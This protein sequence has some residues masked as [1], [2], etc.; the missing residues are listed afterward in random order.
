MAVGG[1][2]GVPVG[3]VDVLVEVVFLFRAIRSSCGKV[4]AVKVTNAT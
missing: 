1:G 4:S 3:G 2:T